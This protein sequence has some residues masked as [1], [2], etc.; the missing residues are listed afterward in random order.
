M[1]KDHALRILVVEDEAL[2]AMEMESILGDAGH[3]VVCLADDFESALACAEK[4][5]PDLALLD[6]QLLRGSSGLD[7]ASAF[8]TRGIPCL[9]VTGNCPVERGRGLGVGCL[10]KPFDE[11]SL[12]NAVSAADAVLHG[13][14]PQNLPSGMHI[15]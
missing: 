10:H 7:V 12:V 5:S 11:R 8:R 9:F 6:I 2:L 15:Y 4:T 14:R 13:G 3:E 1:G